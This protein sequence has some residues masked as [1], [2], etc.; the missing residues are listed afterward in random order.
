MVDKGS[1]SGSF[2][3]ALMH[4]VQNQ[5]DPEVECDD[6]SVAPVVNAGCPRALLEQTTEVR[7]E[8]GWF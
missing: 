4:L 7:N 5:H 2:L 8:R 6:S 3:E 1:I